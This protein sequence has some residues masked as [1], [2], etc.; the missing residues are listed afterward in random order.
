MAY[1]VIGFWVVHI[2]GF[3]GTLWA[4]YFIGRASGWIAIECLQWLGRQC[5]VRTFPCAGGIT[6]KKLGPTFPNGRQSRN[7]GLW[8]T[9]TDLEKETGE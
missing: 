3:C 4:L 5:R 2:T 1:E 9:W 8:L 6:L 7:V